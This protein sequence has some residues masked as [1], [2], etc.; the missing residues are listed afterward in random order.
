MPQQTNLNV[1][2]YF[3]D[4]DANN[5]FH[6]VLFK[7][8]YPV[9]ARELTT[10]QSILQNQIEKFGKHFFKE[11]AK[12]IPGNTGYSQYYYGVQLV[13]SF[14][15]VPVEAYANQLVGTKIT[16]QNSG[17]TAYV[18]KILSSTDSER[19]NLTLYINYLSS[20]TTNNATQTFSDGESLI[21]DTVLSSG[22]L[23]NTT[24]EAGAPFANTLPATAAVTGSSFQ[25]QNGIYFIRGQFVNVA[26]ETL[27]LD[28]YNASPSYRIG[29]LVTE[30]IITAD[31][32][33]TLN[34]NSQGFNNYAAPGA[35]RLKIS[36]QLSK[37]PNIDFQDDDFIELATVTDGVLRS[38]VK[39]TDYESNFMDVLAR[40][41]FAESGHYTVKNF[42]VSVE[43]SLNNNKGNRGL[44]QA[45]QFTPGGTPVT[46]NLGLYK[47]SP[48][49]AF[50][51]GYEVE[52]IGPT[53]LDFN[54]PRTTKTI[55]DESIIYNTGPTIKI[56]N[57]YGVPKVSL[58]ST[59][60]VSLR[61]QRIGS[62][63]EE[64]STGSEIGLARVYDFSLE[65]G[66]YNSSLPATNEW[67][68]SLFDVQTFSIAT[69]NENHTLSVPT[70]IKGLQ[71]G[72]TAFLRSAVTNSK[73]LTLYEVE[74]QFNA[75][76][77]LSFNGVDSG[78]VGVAITNF[79]ISDAK[80]IYGLANAGFSTFNADVIQSPKT[81]VG[82][83]TITAT[84]TSGSIGIST[85]RSTNPR[86]PGNIKENNLVRYSDVNRTG[87]FNS[88][89][90][91][92]RVVSVGAS[93]VTITGINTVTGV[94]I[95]GTVATQ[96]EVQD[97]TVLT[98]QLQSSSDNTLFT[99][100]PKSN[101]ATV[102]LTGA[103]I[104]IRKEF[105]V[106]ISSNQLSTPVSVDENESFLPFDAE[107]YSL[108]RSDGATEVLTSDRFS[109]SNGG[110]TLQILNLGSNNTG[111]T[112]LTTVRK[113][114]P[115]SKVKSLNK[116][117]VLVVDKSKL[118][119]SGTGS[120]TL[121]DGLLYGAYP[122]G[123]RVQD[124][125]ISLNVPD[126]ITI[127]GIFESSDTSEASAPKATFTA[128][129]SSSTT[130]S[131][132]ILGEEIVGQNSG[133]VAII[134]EKL[135]DS[136]ISFVYK[137]DITFREG[138]N[139]ISGDTDIEG[140]IASLDAPSFEISN[141][142]TFVNGQEGTIQNFGFL[143]RKADSLAP[144]KQLKVY[145]SNGFFQSTDDGDITTV[146]SYNAF[147]Y[148][149]EIPNVEQTAVSD[150]IDI[151]PRVSE[152]IVSENSRSPLEFL[153]RSYNASGNSAANTLA[154]D[155]SILINF[156]Y[157]LGRIDR[158]YL[159]KE[160]AFQVKYGEPS[161]RPSKPGPVD[162]AIEIATLTLPPYLY[163]TAQVGI[164]YLE[165]KRFTMSDIRRIENRVRN[166]E[167]Y[168][169]LS[170]LETNT[171][172]LFV[173]DANGLN[174][175]KS[176]FFV[177]NFTGF[178]PQEQ[179]VEI[180]NSI[181]LKNKEL[182]AK[183]YTTSVDLIFGPVV[184][185]DSTQDLNFASIEG[186]NVR[187]SNDVVTLDYAEVEWL[188]Q[189]F[190]T[191]TENVT[192]FLISFWQGSMELTPASDTW[193]DQTR[194]EAKT[195]NIEGNYAETFNA[196]VEAG[197]IDPQTGF[198]PV[199]W[200]SW[201]TNWIGVDVVNTTRERT[202]TRGGEWI[203]WAGQP[204]GGRRPAFGTR[205]TTTIREQI[206]ETR[207]RGIASRT[208]LATVVTEQFDQ[209]STGDRVVS[210]DLVPFMRSRNVEFISKRVKPLTRLYAF[211]DGV[212]VS[213]YCVPKLLE[214]EMLSGTFEIGET[215]T[216][217]VIQTGLGPDVSNTAASIT[218]RVA[219]A[220]HKEGAYNIPTKT[221]PENPYVSGQDLPASY[222]ST[223]TVLNVDTFSLQAEVQGQYQGYVETGMT[224]RGSTSGAR[225]NI[226][227]VRLISDI[228]AHIAG[229]FFIPNPN[230]INHPRFE[231]GTKTFVLINNEDND[232]DIC[233]TISEEAFSASGTLET[234][235]ENIISVRNARVENR[236]QFQSRNVNETLGTE[237][238]N[239]EVTGRRSERVEIG[240]Y[241][242]LAQ[243]FLVEDE[244]GIFLTRCDVYFRTKDD[245]DIP[246]VFQIRSM[247]DGLPSQHV[248]P[249]SE[250]VLDPNDVNVS[251]D[252]SVATSFTFKAPVYLEGGNQEYAIALASNST[253]YTVYV[254]RVGENDLLTQTFISNQPYLGSLFKSQNASTW[255]PSQ[256]EDLKFNL[257]RADFVDNGSVEFYNPE[258]T[259]G[260]N[261]VA[262]LNGNALEVKSRQVRVGLG[263]T[264]GDSTY[265]VGNTFSQLGTNATGDLTGVAGIA[266]GTLNLI[267]VGLGYTP[268][269]GQFQFN[270]V[271]MITVTGSGRGAKADVTVQNGVA[272]AA[273]LG[274]GGSGYQ[275]GDVLTV[276]TIG[277]SSVG[278]NMRLSITGIGVTQELILDN[279][280]GDFVVGAANTVQ[281]VNSS[282]ITTDLN[283]SLGGDVQISSVNVVNDGLHIKVN[284][285]NHGMYFNDNRVTLSGILPDI[286]PT[287][288][289]TAY[290][291]DA[292]TALSV[293]SG[294]GFSTFENVGVGT[295]N[296]GYLLIGNEVIEYDNVSGGNI[297]GN[298]VRGTNPI[299]YPIG[300]PVY[301][302]EL[303]GV[304]LQRINRTH[305][306]NDVTVSNPI[307]FD[308]YN[309]KIDTS[310]TTGTGR[311][312]DVGHPKLY[313]NNTKS[314][315]G[316]NVKAT[317]NI[318]F[319]IITPS[320]QNVTVKG[321]SI[322]AELRSTT[323]KSLSG[324]ELPYLDTGFEP[325]ALNAANY[326]DS[327]R[328]IASKVNEDAKL[329]NTPGQKSMNMRLLMN[330]TDTRVSPVV[331]AQ[332]VSTILTSNRVNNIITN[333]ATDPRVN[334]IENDPTACQ[335]I[336]QEIVLEQSASSIKILAEVHATT[337]ADVRAFYAF[338]VN[339]GK[340]PIFIPFPGYSNLNERGQ[341]INPSNSNGE[342]DVFVTKSNNYAFE[343]QNL[344][345]KEYTFTI[346]DLP[347]FKTYRIK[348]VLTSTSQVHVPR[349]RNLRVIA[350]A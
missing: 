327:P 150:I 115:K 80:S 34:D 123:T 333:Y 315:G 302:Y 217:T 250:V 53:F 265:V 300:T 85:V 317:Q 98:T 281:F 299:A 295:T 177:D 27:I 96:I 242:P 278:Q 264:V 50:V 348:L 151:R 330:T 186:I 37:K 154:S 270:G 280:Q 137:S 298:I 213:K 329:V 42:D 5:D 102:D 84:A 99:V 15:G 286:R 93:H 209:I 91:F 128:L 269:S 141:N 7:P 68:I 140:T 268:A 114:K 164:T 227:N 79:G 310:S 148:A 32:D 176:G 156:S 258:L 155:E 31:I 169:S 166:L 142:Y 293:D 73:S 271:D 153:G 56:N 336:S 296:K 285:K 309:I 33:E 288:L 172:N 46:D 117:N 130:T 303:G 55:E 275:V 71:T 134:A 287:K 161:E 284:H 61:D 311:N 246:V 145:F 175:F 256:W 208:G 194:L 233:T 20:N 249:F 220:N 40:R 54:K 133:A 205:T 306:L 255:E 86:F 165:H 240:W 195:V 126:I 341:V 26:T 226:T 225:A 158:I 212:D 237:V 340:E 36:A 243:S 228:A 11:G 272:I 289:S 47:I 111:A 118:S 231:V 248:L 48:G 112:L 193:V 14:N 322:S 59:F 292:T 324:S 262:T 234:V 35:D 204:G 3:D 25:I 1:A 181:D 23:G 120:T 78:Y 314:T 344:D 18:D 95:G 109:F 198:G 218:F 139:I 343:S 17:V 119:A 147:D 28:Q 216:G 101:I 13:N 254:S 201:E 222:S 210:R 44:F 4:F 335:Y 39:N 334:V 110:K 211:F 202:E 97:F 203:G 127:H 257:Y 241:D 107:R 162:D 38:K 121:N 230:N 282:G 273:T 182:R 29:L 294:N 244:T 184:N 8:G 238:V 49:R 239:S 131:E 69:L 149:T 135:S 146:E 16:G 187:K 81:L 196:A 45:G 245:M 307:S 304:S 143:K 291:A 259:N 57:V 263:T 138:E 197:Q 83:A 313:L 2:P 337:N 52:T 297:G 124:E 224:L 332:R 159:T 62:D 24:I 51:K 215:V 92:A 179:Y 229:S 10:L 325:I 67:D 65:S 160:G 108:I 319:E 21:C 260:N 103:N 87:N 252:G 60:T 342:S 173:P 192:P 219:A 236:Q 76:E 318:P 349:L 321:T 207:R 41:T 223:S 136:Q 290:G 323:S 88:D 247:K 316:Y 206:Q 63:G 116:V 9:Q 320:V 199:I 180:K 347:E 328:M 170:L 178:K 267:N 312:T 122:F 274:S 266:T 94:A 22:L 283:Y 64:P 174:R 105:T 113:E 214:I 277:L 30:E 125:R 100:L 339:E 144:S 326:L 129:N 66:S 350:L 279:V 12:V 43:N 188:S 90:V 185:Q 77:P 132:F 6:K 276:N 58:G 183:H 301:K 232:Q 346:D 253:K 338:N 157:Y 171:A 19:G 75:F 221:Y 89:P 168:T 261:Q 167:F 331:D 305:N 74:G 106:N 308:S 152:Y 70:F 251:A 104:T 190:A 235:Q 82:V 163:N 200:D 72:A 189:T 191:R 345:F